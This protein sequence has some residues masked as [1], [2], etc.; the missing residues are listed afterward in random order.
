MKRALELFCY[1]AC[2]HTPIDRV[3]WRAYMAMLPYAG[4]EAYR[5]GEL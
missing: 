4:S 2:F 3:S 1:V 5:R